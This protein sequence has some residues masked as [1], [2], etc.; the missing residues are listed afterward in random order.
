MRGDSVTSSGTTTKLDTV[1][2]P[3]KRM[4]VKARSNSFSTRHQ[5]GGGSDHHDREVDD[6]LMVFE[7]VSKA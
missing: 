4:R 5:G 3:K 7:A 6:D 1:S 2:A